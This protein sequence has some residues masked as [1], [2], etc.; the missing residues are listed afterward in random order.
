MAKKQQRKAPKVAQK[1]TKNSK[2]KRQERKGKRWE[3]CKNTISTIR[4]N[5]G[6]VTT[7]SSKGRHPS[8]E[9]RLTSGYGRKPSISP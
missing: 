9:S 1:A 4:K 3:D 2:C 5:A 7:P 8:D 6:R